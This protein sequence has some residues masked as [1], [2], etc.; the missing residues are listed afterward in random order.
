ML[1]AIAAT[2]VNP[3]QINAK[4]ENGIMAFTV[5]SFPFSVAVRQ[6]ASEPL[7]ELSVTLHLSHGHAHAGTAGSS[8]ALAGGPGPPGLGRA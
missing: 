4:M 8:A 7:P 1:P 3:S 2:T 5:T 6:V